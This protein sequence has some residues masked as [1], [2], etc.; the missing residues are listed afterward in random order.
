[1]HYNTP[2]Q[3]QE[4]GLK[5]EETQRFVKG[6]FRDGTLKT[7]GTYIDRILPPVSRFSPPKVRTEKKQGGLMKLL[8]F[9]EKYFS[10]I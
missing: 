8:A 3:I 5:P 6:S 7:I 2:E 10:L 9:F 1:M 4:E